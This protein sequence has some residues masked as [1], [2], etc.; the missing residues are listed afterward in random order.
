MTSPQTIPELVPNPGPVLA[1]GY[2]AIPTT[3]TPNLGSSTSN[4]R[5]CLNTQQDSRIRQNGT[6]TQME[7]Y[8]GAIPVELTAFYV[9]VWRKN[10]AG[11]YDRVSSE[12]VLPRLTEG[13]N[14]VTLT[15]P[16]AVREGDFVGYVF[17]GSAPPGNFLLTL[18]GYSGTRYTDTEPNETGYAWESAATTTSPFFPIRTYVSPG[19]SIACIGDSIIQGFPDHRT[20]CI[21]NTMRDAPETTVPYSLGARLDVAYQNMGIG[22]QVTTEI[23]ARFANDIVALAPRMAV[24][25]GGINDITRGGTQETYIANWTTMLDACEAAGIIPVCL[26]I[27]PCSNLSNSQQRKRESWNAALRDLVAQYSSAVYVDVTPHVGQY[28]PGGDAG[29]LWDIIPEYAG[30]GTHYTPAGRTLIGQVIADAIEREYG[31]AAIYPSYLVPGARR[32]GLS[33]F[34]VPGTL[35]SRAVEVAGESATVDATRSFAAAPRFAEVEV[36]G[37]ALDAQAYL[38]A[39]PSYLVPGARRFGLSRFSIPG[40]LQSR[41]GAIEG[42]EGAIAATRDP[43]VAADRLAAIAGLGGYL[44]GRS[45]AVPDVSGGV[46][47]VFEE[48]YPI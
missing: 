33:R 20:G 3:G 2:R 29:N 15:A 4:V 12:D 45:Y 47:V 22:G 34:S 39:A 32:F 1:G 40:T 38:V 19:P 37:G 35:Q 14:L 17:T 23:A 28:R 44:A 42:A 25:E 7:F 18:P 5:Y 10:A 36:L 41:H 24:I 11:T 27:F 21:N 9:Q 6:L 46:V 48:V 26:A 43:L 16:V 30:D 13:M 8:I 31:S